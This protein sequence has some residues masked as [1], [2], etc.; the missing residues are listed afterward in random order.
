MPRINSKAELKALRTNITSKR[1]LSKPYI[2]ICSGTACHATGS[3]AVA[4]A[5]QAELEKQGL[6]EDVGVRRTGCHG[7][8][9]RG[10]II[11][12]YPGELCYLNVTPEDVPEIIA[13]TIK[14]NEIIERLL[15]YD[16]ST[17]ERI[18]H[19]QEIPFYKYQTRVVFSGNLWVDPA[20]VND[21][22]ALG[23]YQALAKVLHDM[24]PEEVLEE[25]N[26]ANLRG[27][28]GGGFPAGRKWESTRNAAGTPKYAI[29]NCDEGDPGAYMDR[30]IMEGN[31]HRVLEGLAIAAYAIGSQQGFVYVRQEYPLAVKNLAIALEQAREYGFLGKDI[32]GSGFEFDVK[33]HRGAGAFVSGESSALMNAIEGKVGEP[34][35]KYVHTSDSGIW[36]KPSSLNNVETY[37]TVPLIIRKGADWFNSIGTEGSKGTKIFSLVGKVNNTGLVEVPMGTT[38]REIIYKIGGGIRGGKN[39]KAVQT[40][41]P[42]GGVIPEQYLDTPVDFDALTKL[43]SMM[44]SGGM[45]VMDEDT[46][47]VDIARYF[48]DFLCNESCGK[49]VPC[50]EGL[51]RMREILNGIVAGKGRE[52]DIE[53]LKDIADVMKSASLCALGKTAANPVLSTIRYFSD[54]YEAHI[55]E[56]RCPALVCKDLISYYIEPDKCTACRLCMK[57]CPK[58]AIEGDKRVIHVIDQTKCIKCGIC[59]DVCPSKVGAVM[60]ISGEPVPSPIPEVERVIERGRERAE[61][62]REK[63]EGQ[64]AKEG[65]TSNENGN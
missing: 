7:F 24:T 46:C 5:I 62:R 15:Y 47:I 53:L 59:Y 44:G 28:G 55:K 6:T 11:V 1:D 42:S 57:N 61:G 16:P 30:S 50:R 34:R 51:K 65:G 23:G 45:I 54:E 48:V 3:D 13:K 29:V 64:R 2:T 19:E 21:Y 31:P 25:V 43:G 52:G 41:G 35:P 63:R 37:A 39:F 8:C 49:C 14:E 38:L 22:I 40:G 10:P 36:D 20:N 32:L 9:E 56:R 33:V 12:I 4:A 58:G 27:R 17:G 26:S 18:V 60:K